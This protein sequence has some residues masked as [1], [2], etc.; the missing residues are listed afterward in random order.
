MTEE[1]LKALMQ[2]FGLTASLEG[3]NPQYKILVENFLKEHLNTEL[4]EKYLLIFEEY[5]NLRTVDVAKDGQKLTNIRASSRML[6][7]C[8]RINQEL[9]QQQKM[10][11]MVRMLEL[12]NA[13]GYISNTELEFLHTV[14]A[15]FNIEPL[16]IESILYLINNQLVNGI[17]EEQMLYISS[18]Y[19]SALHSIVQANFSG[20]LYILR[21]ESLDTYLLKY[22][23]EQD[24]YLNGFLIKEKSLYFFSQGSV[25]RG[26]RIEPIYYSDVVSVFR[27]DKN[28][29]TFSFEARDVTCLYAGKKNGVRHID[30]SE[31]SGRLIGIMGESGAGKSTLLELLNGSM[32]PQKGEVL[33]NG[34]SVHQAQIKG[35]IGY[36][37]QDDLLVENL[38]V[39]ENLYFAAKLS[40]G[41]L[42]EKE[43][44]ERVKDMLHSLGLQEIQDL[45][46]GTPL[47]KSI[48][49]GQRKRLNIGLELLRKP[50]ILFVDEPTSGLSSRDSESIMDLLKELTSEGKL[51]F[52]VIHQPSSSVFKMFDKFLI[53]DTG[54]YPIYYGSPADMITYF[55]KHANQI[56]RQQG[57]C[58][59]CGN[60]NVEQVFEIIS[61]KIVNEYGRFTEKR[62]ISPLQWYEMYV[63]SKKTKKVQ[64]FKDF[65]GNTHLHL[66]NRFKQWKFFLERD[67]LSK[68]H[69]TQY[70]LINLLQAPLLAFLLAYVN[71]YYNTE[72]GGYT[73]GANE[74]L[75]AYIF[76]A[77]IVAIFSG[78]VG[79]AEE[80]ISDR[81]VLKREKFINLSRSSYLF[82]KISVMFLISA[83]Q[84]FFL[85]WIGNSILGIKALFWEY[86][87]LLF[88][89]SA[90][91]NMLGLNISSAFR[92]AITVYILIPLLLIPQ[93]VLGGIVIRF[94]KVNPDFKIYHSDHIPWFANLLASRWAFE[95]LIVTQFKDNEYEK[96][97]FEWEKT[98]ATAAYKKVFYMDKLIEVFENIDK[99]KNYKELLKN[100]LLDEFEQI[101]K[102]ELPRIHTFLSSTKK[103]KDKYFLKLLEKMKKYYNQKQYIAQSQKD[104]YL[105]ANP[106]HKHKRR[107]YF[108]EALANL[109]K[110]METEKKIIINSKQIEPSVYNVL[111]D[112]KDYSSHFFAPNK[113]IGDVWLQTFWFNLIII[114]LMTLALYVLLYLNVLEKLFR[115]WF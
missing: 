85:V 63:K 99:N 95:A 33:I 2:L 9:T 104:N 112:A 10:V 107:L 76:I 28:L 8:T 26:N 39:Y 101:D 52:V 103:V 55:K 4:S 14:A 40:L 37:P 13:D 16:E 20:L 86:W 93:L 89:S 7:I 77:I 17:F 60:V 113:K 34:V 44:K 102:A 72:K 70:W 49:G 24:Y 45:R 11:V 12:T 110:N 111:I 46:V 18:N 54:G 81:K 25:I 35:L 114:W 75:P 71:R 66:P 48:S 1:I 100:E 79:S 83:I 38:S 109:A 22:I 47:Q 36:V 96:P 57:E 32:K 87:L 50:S 31:K 65:E 82:A 90:F 53:L 62:K 98:L 15:I 67:I 23:G 42:S 29:E 108:N 3:T 68:M 41:E 64:N 59:E 19:V 30:I 21:I 88:S 105:R 61:A 6:V 73:F 5:A 94:E 51:V 84:T 43:I 58:L 106:S 27:K 91:A 92:S 97:L 69:N 78:L 74:N 56:S 80:I 115:K